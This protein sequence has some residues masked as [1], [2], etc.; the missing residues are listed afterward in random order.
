MHYFNG[1]SWLAII[2]GSK[3]MIVA[4]SANNLIPPAEE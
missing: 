1:M 3:T 2:T 4:D